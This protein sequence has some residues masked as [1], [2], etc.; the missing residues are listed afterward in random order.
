[1]LQLFSGLSRSEATIPPKLTRL[2]VALDIFPETP[3]RPQQPISPQLIEILCPYLPQIND[4]KIVL[5]N[6]RAYK[7]SQVDN[8][9]SELLLTIDPEPLDACLAASMNNP[10]K[11]II[12]EASTLFRPVPQIK[13][14]SKMYEAGAVA[15][16]RKRFHRTAAM[17]E[18]R[19]KIIVDAT[20]L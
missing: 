15:Y 4:L 2:T 16:L 20:E 1:M 11:C 9:M 18:E 14:D 8:S 7:A 17:L 10:T 3:R 19:F 13:F 12:M 6:C 5:R